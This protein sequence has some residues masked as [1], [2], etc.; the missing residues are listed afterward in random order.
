MNIFYTGVG[1]KKNG[2]HTE[3]EFLNVMNKNFNEQCSN[4]LPELYNK[5]CS[6]YKKLNGKFLREQVGMEPI[7]FSKSKKHKRRLRTLLKKCNQYKKTLKRKE[8]NL[9]EYIKFSGAEK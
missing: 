1:S 8:C 7:Q 6:N 5:S 9:D 3:K 2:K 4:Y